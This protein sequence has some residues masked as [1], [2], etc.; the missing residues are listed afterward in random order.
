MGEI[1]LDKDI[2]YDYLFNELSLY[3]PIDYQISYEIPVTPSMDSYCINC[4]KESTFKRFS[5]SDLIPHS[6]IGTSE[7]TSYMFRCT[8][9]ENHQYTM[10]LQTAGEKTMKIGQYPSL[11]DLASED[12]KKYKKVLASDFGNFKEAIGLNAHG[13]GAGSFV[14]L[15]RIFENLIEEKRQLALE[16][17]TDWSDEIFSHSKMDEKIKLLRVYLPDFLVENRKIY[18]ILSKGIH[19]LDDQECLELFPELRL[20]IELILDEKLSDIEKKQK[21]NRFSKFVSTT[22]AALK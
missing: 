11:R 21:V 3:T 2:T 17:Q 8:R 16:E 19:E 1:Y 10:I 13:V 12:I 7:Y 9:N 4:G 18:S 14:Y 22:V 5:L 6:H 15:R 20:A